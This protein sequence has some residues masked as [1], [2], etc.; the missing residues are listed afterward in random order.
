MP[1]LQ[2]GGHAAI[3]HT[4]LCNYTILAIQTGGPWHNAPLL[5]YAPGMRTI[6]NVVRLFA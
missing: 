4:V 3:L 1:N 6:T 2:R 5:K